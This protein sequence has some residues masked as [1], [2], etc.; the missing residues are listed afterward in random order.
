MKF[1][2][3][4]LLFTI[5]SQIFS[6]PLLGASGEEDNYQ[7]AIELKETFDKSNALKDEKQIPFDDSIT[8][9]KVADE[10]GFGWNLG[11]TLD[12]WRGYKQ[13]QGLKSETFW[14]IAYTTEEVIKGLADK[15]IK[16]VRI[17]VTWHNHIIDDNYTI[18][19]EWMARVKEIVD[20][21]LKYGLYVILNTHHDNRESKGLIYGDGYY[22]LRQDMVE[23]EKFLYNTY[24]QIALA[25]NNGYDH[26]LIFE[27]L[28]EPRLTATDFEWNFK[29]GEPICEEASSV[30]NEYLKLAVRAI[31]TSGGNNEKRFIMVTPLAA[32]YSSAVNQDFIF[33]GDSKYNPTNPKILLSVHMYLPYI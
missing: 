24:R 31:R 33:P 16:T 19:P 30:L 7:F 1:Q 13:D 10:M 15:G 29:K 20:W 2:E 27:A 6:A 3:M 25:F 9:K 21:S 14:G 22:P 17:P 8:S 5:L 32:A 26:H 28:N 11:N 12:A 4:I 18:D 23:S